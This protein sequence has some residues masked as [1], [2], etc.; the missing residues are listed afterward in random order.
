MSR[1][2]AVTDLGKQTPRGSYRDA[3][4]DNCVKSLTDNAKR[5]IVFAGQREDARTVILVFA[6]GQ[7]ATG[8]GAGEGKDHLA[9]ARP[10]IHN[11]QPLNSSATR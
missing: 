3:P 2:H 8:N 1:L 5:R 9:L 6:D 7:R 11:G 4:S 10:V